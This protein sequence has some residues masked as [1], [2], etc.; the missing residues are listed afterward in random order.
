MKKYKLLLLKYLNMSTNQD[1]N[2]IYDT[3]SYDFIFRDFVRKEMG[4]RSVAI[5]RILDDIMFGMEIDHKNKLFIPK[6]DQSHI[7]RVVYSDMQSK[8][9]PI[10]IKM[11]M[12]I[13]LKL[14]M[15]TF[16]FVQ[17]R[18]ADLEQLR[19]RT[20]NTLCKWN[21]L[22]KNNV[23]ILEP[24]RAKEATQQVI[25]TAMYGKS[26]HF[27][28][29]LFNVSELRAINELIGTIFTSKR[30]AIILDE[31]DFL[32]SG[33]ESG[34]VVEFEK[35]SKEAAFIYNV[36][37]TP[38]TTLAHRP[39]LS[40]HFHV[41][42][43]PNG[44][45][46]LQHINWIQTDKKSKPSNKTTDNPFNNDKH[47]KIFLKEYHQKPLQ[48]VSVEGEFVPNYLLVR[49]GKT[50]EPQL[51]AAEYTHK[52]YPET[53][54][55]TWNGGEATI[56]SSRLKKSPIQIENVK[57]EFNRVG[58]YHT[59]G[60]IHIGKIISYLYNL[61]VDKIKHIIVYAGQLADRGITFGADNLDTCKRL[62]KAWWHL[63]DMYYVGS[64]SSAAQNMGN[65]LQ[66]CGRLCGVYDDN[67]T[68][69][70]YT[71]SVERVRD[72]Y[73]LEREIIYRVK[74][75]RLGYVNII[76]D[77]SATILKHMKIS[78]SKKVKR[79]RITNEKVE[80]EWVTK[81]TFVDGSDTSYGGLNNNELKEVLDDN[82]C[83]ILSECSSDS[84]IIINID[85]EPLPGT[86]DII[87]I[88]N[89]KL[90]DSNKKYV[91]DIQS[92]IKEHNQENNW[93]R[94]AEIVNYFENK[95]RSNT[96]RGAL[97]RMGQKLF[98][99]GNRSDIVNKGLNARKLTNEWEFYLCT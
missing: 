63:T 90:S 17:N 76:D 57:S 45:K 8:K 92:Y 26:S 15:P 12:C 48:K 32:D 60:S 98:K 20:S 69:T 71:N 40:Q 25:K 18:R 52:R 53:T 36:S 11:A 55:I 1:E 78:K 96:I 81:D 93:V 33:N 46:G 64:T 16:L 4:E 88:H 80:N 41:L 14:K 66:T 99:S 65:I 75:K 3:F 2:K 73:K 72:A 37:A 61:G 42:E 59:F 30:Y 24:E 49:L 62:G 13:V 67:I 19:N 38:I 29:S 54:V 79:M 27:F 39:C 56:R 68:L 89:I 74:N 21:N 91:N 34:A 77:D 5:E 6:Y 51:T 97:T 83:E 95:H 43:P 7:Y 85:D 70:L 28:I 47:L 9:T 35:F 31:A 58:N 10:M 22:V 87:W 94:R 82:L 84:Y 44:Y 86:G 23:T 50:I